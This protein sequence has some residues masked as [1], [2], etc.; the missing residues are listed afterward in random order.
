MTIGLTA[1]PASTYV[2]RPVGYGYDD[3]DTMWVQITGVID[4]VSTTTIGR[5]D[6]WCYKN[7]LRLLQVLIIRHTYARDTFMGVFV[8][9]P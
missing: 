4:G 9:N 2:M 8:P 5:L 3:A 6:N 7:G 1:K